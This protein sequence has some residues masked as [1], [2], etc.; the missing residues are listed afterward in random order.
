MKKK[1]FAVVA[2]LIIAIPLFTFTAFGVSPR[3]TLFRSATALCI[4]SDNTYYA[5]VSASSDVTRIDLYLVLYEKG[6][7]SSYSEVSSLSR[8]VYSNATTV[9]NNYNYSSLKSYK[10]VL[11]ATARTAS[12][13]TETITVSEEY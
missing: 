8:T 2:A 12:G 5:D 6:L 7:F 1:V 13:Q 3:W 11:T 9:Y 4:E 10:V